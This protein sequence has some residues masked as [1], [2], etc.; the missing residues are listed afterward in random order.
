MHAM[1][2]N[3]NS[4][5]LTQNTQNNLRNSEWMHY[6]SIEFIFN[7]FTHCARTS[8]ELLKQKKNQMLYIYELQTHQISKN[9]STSENLNQKKTILMNTFFG[10]P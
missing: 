9:N 1:Q 6:I 10:S 7:I 2:H 5:S 3:M 8:R 4:Q